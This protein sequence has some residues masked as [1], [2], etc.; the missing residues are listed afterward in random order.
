MLALC[1]SVVGCCRWILQ[2]KVA[3]GATS[4]PHVPIASS[5]HSTMEISPDRIEEV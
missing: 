3:G 1:A 5:L 4:P 2:R